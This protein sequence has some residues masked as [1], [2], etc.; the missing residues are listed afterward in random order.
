MDL[1]FLTSIAAI[2]AVSALLPLGVYWLRERRARSIRSALRLDEPSLRARVPL[3][4]AIA[5]VPALLGVAAAQPVLGT[6]R[7]VPERTDVEAFFV[8]DTSRSMLASSGPDGATRFE[9]AVDAASA[10]HDRI[11]QVRSGIISMTDRIL[12]HVLPTTDRRVFE[13]TLRRSIGVELPPPASTY[14]TYATSYD[15]LA[16]IPERRYFSPT[17]KKRVL[18]VL[19]DGESR[20]FGAELGRA[21]PGKPPIDTVIVRFWDAGE[22]IYE[23]GESEGG[24]LPD[25]NSE[26]M[27]DR[28]AELTGGRAFSEDE[29]SSAADAVVDAVGAG[30][31]SNR[32]IAGA[33]LA[34]MPWVTLAAFLPLVF[35]LWRRN[36]A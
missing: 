23:T 24:Y 18:V 10:I 34:L 35:L 2:F 16:G 12:P 31:T 8:L 7:S 19:T 17:A 25:K 13:A 32:T 4:V 36:R 14:S 15:V 22:R 11:P 20:P 27:I 33:R 28:L 3:V 1:T 6:E 5:A 9:R 26:A 29:L 30:E 21:F